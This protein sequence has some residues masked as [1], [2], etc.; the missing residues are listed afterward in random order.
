M[1]QPSR[2]REEADLLAFSQSREQAVSIGD[3]NE[4]H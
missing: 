1:L 3:L 4:H 2:D